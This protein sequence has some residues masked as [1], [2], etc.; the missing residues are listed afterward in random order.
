MEEGSERGEE[1]V[2]AGHVSATAAEVHRLGEIHH[3]SGECVCVCV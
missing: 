3:E 1:L 2:A